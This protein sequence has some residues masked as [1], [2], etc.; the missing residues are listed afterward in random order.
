MFMFISYVFTKGN[1]FLACLYVIALL[2]AFKGSIGVGGWL[3]KLFLEKKKKNL[4]L[5]KTS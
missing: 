3:A 2:S 5:Q 1:N 4:E